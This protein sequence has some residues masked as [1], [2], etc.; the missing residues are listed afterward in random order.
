MPRKRTPTKLRLLNGTA[1]PHRHANR[2]DTLAA[3]GKPVRRDDFTADEAQIWDWVIAKY[4]GT[5]V[6]EEIDTPALIQCC[7]LY[8]MY[9]QVAALAKADPIDKEM[10]CAVIG[11]FAAFSKVAANFGMTPHD[12]ANIKGLDVAPADE[13]EEKYG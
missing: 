11:Y 7:E 12:R 4:A 2:L 10:R 13:L 3:K 1:R 6:L 8:G 5:Q 9:R